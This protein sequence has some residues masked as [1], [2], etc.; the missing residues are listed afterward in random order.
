MKKKPVHRLIK[1]ERSG[2]YDRIFVALVFTLVGFGILMIYNST[3]IH[4]QNIYGNAY[5]F[6][7]LH[8]GWVLMAILAFIVFLNI[9]YKRLRYFS[10]TLFGTSIMM[11]VILA[12]LGLIPC[13]SSVSF[14]PCINGAN[15]WLYLNPPPLPE[16]PLIG[17]VGFQPSELAKLAL[18]LYLSF[19][20]FKIV[21][22][23]E[24]T[25]WVYLISSCLVA[26]LVLIQPNM[27]TAV[28][29]FMIGTIIYF[30]SGSPFKKLLIMAPIVLLFG[31]GFVLSSPYRRE[32]FLTW[33]NENN[34]SGVEQLE[35]SYHINQISIALGS[36]GFSGLGFGKSRQKY[37]YLPEVASDSIFAIIGEEFGFI[38][39]LVLTT[40]FLFFL[41][42][43][44]MISIRSQDVLGKMIS[45]GIISWIGIQFLV[46]VAAMSRIIPLTGV[47]IP[48]ISYGGS[49]LIFSM[50]GLGIVANISRKSL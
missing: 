24:N 44:F 11:L 40:V 18:I 32:R 41:Y 14:A 42:K 45:T 22:E 49:S 16:L 20:L 17:V 47:P 25:F 43:G 2:K 19:Q 27:S 35:S 3:I 50:I 28:M 29:L 1:K 15:R 7:L 26:F 6:V 9:D 33:G 5:R 36:G 13:E 30:A 46:N 23:K 4:S 21:Q 37:Q 48:L 34:L 38:G 8:I 39:T 31:L 10:Y 12:L